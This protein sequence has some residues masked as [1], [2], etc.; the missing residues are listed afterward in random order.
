MYPGVEE[1]I[2]KLPAKYQHFIKFDMGADL[3]AHA[4]NAGKNA[5]ADFAV[6][7]GLPTMLTITG[8]G[9]LATSVG[10]IG[11]LPTIANTAASVAG[12]YAGA[13]GGE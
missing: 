2:A 4:A 1:A 3:T 11:F 9:P 5:F 13:K 6:Q 12:G 8:L 7:Y 10:S